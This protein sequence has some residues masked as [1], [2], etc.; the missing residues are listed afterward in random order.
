MVLLPYLAERRYDAGRRLFRSGEEAEQL[1]F[2]LEGE[3]R[4]ELKRIPLCTVGAGEMIGGLS[5]VV[6]GRRRCDVYAQETVLALALE[7]SAY[8]RLRKEAPAV[9]LVIQEAIL[10][11]F[12]RSVCATDVAD[13]SPETL[14][15]VD[16][17]EAAD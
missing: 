8:L 6:V 14:A 9:A 11:A 10:R 7:R 2:L 5:L 15:A 13:P 16:G 12:V 4:V 17:T 3:A 1:L